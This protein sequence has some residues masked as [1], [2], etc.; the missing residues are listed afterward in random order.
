MH[1]SLLALDGVIQV[2]Q[3][4]GELHGGRL[5]ASGTLNARHNAVTLDTSG[6]ISRLDIASSTGC[7]GVKAD[8]HRQRHRGLATAQPGV[9]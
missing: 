8:A 4:T 5:E 7:N 2:T 3:L 6:S 1:A 9:F